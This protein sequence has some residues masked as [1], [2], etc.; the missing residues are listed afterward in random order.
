MNVFYMGYMSLWVTACLYATYLLIRY[1]TSF[2]IFRKMYY[3]Y[4]FQAWKIST[5]F[6]ALSA[7]V[8]L[9]PYTGDPT[10]DYIDASFMSILTFLTAPWSAGIIYLTIKRKVNAFVTYVAICAWLFSA[11]WS[12][13]G[14]LVIR[15][16]DYPLTWSANL[17]ASSVIYLAAGL[18]WNLD[19]D[20]HRG[21]IFGFMR[22]DWLTSSASGSFKKLVWYAIPLMLIAAG[23]FVPFAL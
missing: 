3:K 7:F 12:Y 20:G 8:G 11:S 16:G 2:L 14:Y 17:V 6:I 18:F 23:V 15:D 5:F 21:V 19:D 4:L 22:E 1:R 9:S 13:D 10:W